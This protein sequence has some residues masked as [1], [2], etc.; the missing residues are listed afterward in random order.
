MTVAVEEFHE[1]HCPNQNKEA[2]DKTFYGTCE[3][4]EAIV[5]T[6]HEAYAE[7]VRDEIM[8]QND[9]EVLGGNS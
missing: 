3:F 1:K 4:C 8:R 2:Y 7:G 9:I 6:Y 5:L